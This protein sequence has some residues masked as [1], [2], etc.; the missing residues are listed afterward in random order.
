MYKRER[1]TDD[2]RWQVMRR[3]NITCRYCGNQ[4]G[5]FHIDHVYPVSKG[6]ATSLEN[7]VTSCASCNLKKHD[8]VGV[9][10]PSGIKPLQAVKVYRVN[11]KVTLNPDTIV[12]VSSLISLLGVIFSEDQFTSGLFIGMALFLVSSAL[13]YSVILSIR[14]KHAERVK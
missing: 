11:T 4:S 14:F 10:W 12:I 6:G 1:I 8:S 9:Y 5:P 13:V 7:L 2:L 3:D